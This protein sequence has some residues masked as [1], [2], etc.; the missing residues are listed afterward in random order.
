MVATVKSAV[1]NFAVEKATVET[2]DRCGAGRAECLIEERPSR[3][4]DSARELGGRCVPGRR[5]EKWTDCCELS[6]R[7]VSKESD[8]PVYESENEAEVPNGSR[9]SAS[10]TMMAADT[11]MDIFTIQ[12]VTWRREVDRPLA[13]SIDF[14]EKNNLVQVVVFEDSLAREKNRR[15]RAIP[16]LCDHDLRPGDFIVI[17]DERTDHVDIQQVLLTST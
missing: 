14:G 8:G 9:G 16:E 7:K 11:K 3:H 1:E 17:V 2:S 4:G 15:I 6:R 12:W 5:K 10:K 13:E